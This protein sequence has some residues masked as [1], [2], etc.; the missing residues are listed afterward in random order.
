M[1]ISTRGRYS[2]RMMIDLSQHYNEGFIALKDISER[3][4]ISKKYLEQIVPFLNRSGL[5]IANRGHLGGYQ[6]ARPPAEITV[7]DIILSA[8]G[9]IY[10]VSCMDN[11]PN[12]CPNKDTCLTL[13]IWEGLH[14]VTT[15]YLNSITLLDILNSQKDI[16]DYNI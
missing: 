12:L 5:L 15:N 4:N 2:L 11:N 6:L 1:K 8:E 10:S 16:S 3:Q 7:Y 14:E 13:P 9:S